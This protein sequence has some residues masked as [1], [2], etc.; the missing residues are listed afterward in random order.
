MVRLGSVR[1]GR[2]GEAFLRLAGTV[3]ESARLNEAGCDDAFLANGGLGGLVGRPIRD[4]GETRLIGGSGDSN[5]G[6]AR[7]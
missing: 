7:A 3:G 2:V 4:P 1:G 6:P 5:R